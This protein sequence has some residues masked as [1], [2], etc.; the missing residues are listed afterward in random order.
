MIWNGFLRPSP[1]S[2]DAYVEN[3]ADLDRRAIA[4]SG[5]RGTAATLSGTW[6]KFIFQTATTIALAHLLTPLD[7]GLVA[8]VTAISGFA[9]LMRDLGLSFAVVQAPRLSREQASTLFW[10]SSGLGAAGAITLVAIGPLLT[11]FYHEPHITTIVPLIAVGL[12]VSSLGGQ[13]IALLDRSLGFTR[14]MV[15]DVISS[16]ASCVVALVFATLGW[17]YWALV[18]MSVTQSVTRTALAWI[19]VRWVP[20][21]PAPFRA[22]SSLVFFGSNLLSA[23][24]LNYF[25]RNLDDVIVGRLFGARVL[26]Q[27]AQ[28]YQLLLLPLQQ[29]NAPLQRVAVPL[30]SRTTVEPSLYR[31]YFRM[32]IRLMTLILIPIFCVS[33]ILSNGLV[34]LLLGPQWAQC[35]GLFRILCIAGVTQSLGYATSWLFIS[36]G[37]GRRQLIYA[38][39][40][41]PLVIV[42]FLVGAQWGVRGLALGYALTSAS[43]V[44]PAFYY[45]MKN[46]PARMVDLLAGMKALGV[47]LP[48]VCY[49]AYFV[50]REGRRLGLS[51][52]FAFIA[53]AGASTI[54]YIMLWLLIPSCRRT[55]LRLF[56]IMRSEENPE[57]QAATQRTVMS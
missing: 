41:R 53:A 24:I 1:Y 32:A 37:Q 26:G 10:Y 5:V 20:G 31:S 4:R 44:I 13:H 56:R 39:V 21:R 43:F 14:V 29:V 46:T 55:A 3:G 12:F 28:A 50:N 8:M 27:Y 49:V 16:S 15:S 48:S 2:F 17:G 35:A 25:S 52:S 23:Q 54:V 51:I 9:D 18:G 38:L 11:D 6:V 33:A 22:V 40:S 42:S 19:N 47:M 57:A 30:L 45:A 36:T 7:F 34:H